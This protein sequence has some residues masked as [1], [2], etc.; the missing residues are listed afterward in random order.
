MSEILFL[1]HRI[2]FPPDRGDKIRSHHLLKRLAAIAPVHVATFADDE[3]DAAHE[4]ELAIT[5]RSWRLV[6]RR[7]PL[8]LAG[9]MALARGLPV[10]LTA[11]R[12]SRIADFVAE[13]LRVRS[14]STIVVFSG[15][16][17]QYVPADF[18][19]QVIVDF[20]DVDSAKFDAYAA[21]ARWP[22]RWVH[23]R[24][25]RLLAAEEA[26]V[27]M[28][29]DA[30]LFISPEE[31]ALFSAR[32]APAQRARSSLVTLGNGIDTDL[33]D[34]AIVTPEP[35][36]AALSGPPLIFT[37][38]MDYPPN[39][40]AVVRA[41]TRVM[42]LIRAVVPDATFHVVGRKPAPAVMAL[43]GV[44]GTHV[45][46]RVEDVRPWL[47]GADLALVPLQIGR[48]VQ[49]KVLEAMAM[50][51]PVVASPQAATGIPA[52]AARDLAIGHSD[53]DLAAQCLSLLADRRGARRIGLA[54]RR[55]VEQAHNW[56]AVLAPL[57]ALIAVGKARRN[58]A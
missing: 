2:P 42:P 23:A 58:A 44:N 19:G 45:W 4:V 39:V 54:A 52:V 49:N 53:E 41:A 47:K 25:G 29:A 43:Q 9:A 18:A 33:F 34:P 12:D 38:Q 20:V 14:I 22:M 1:S 35:Q 26:R 5:A 28:R 55:F 24:E 3:Q 50:A 32:L 37:G 51:L 10:S 48:G 15:Q 36:M 31:S 40:D 13:T 21:D 11:F 8:P 30:A 6:R 7:L 56:D 46:G 16:M 27:A 57:P 17:A